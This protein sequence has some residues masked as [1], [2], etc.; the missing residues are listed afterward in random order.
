MDKKKIIDI[1][2]SANSAKLL[3]VDQKNWVKCLNSIS[4]QQFV[5]LSYK[6]SF[7]EYQKEYFSDVYEEYYDISMVLYR[8]GIPVGIWPL[9]IYKID[10]MYHWGS[11]GAYI[12]EPI[13]INLPKSEAQ[14]TVIQKILESFVKI[15]DQSEIPF[16]TKIKSQI[17]IMENGSSQWQRKWM[18]TGARCINTSWWAY[19]DLS[20]SQEEIQSRIR[21][22]NKYSIAKGETDYDIEIYDSDDII[23]SEVFSEFHKMH[24]KISGRETRSQ[25]TWD[26]QERS[27]R[28]NNDIM[29]YDFVIFIRDKKTRELAGSSLFAT[30]PQS[31]L[32]CV[33]AYD[34]ERFSKPV[35]HIVQAVA[36]EYMRKR[37]VR[38]YEIGE[39]VY[40]NDNNSN[41][42][43]VNIGKYKEGFATHMFPKIVMQLD[44]EEVK[45]NI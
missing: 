31:G 38:W 2:L 39:R 33:A 27:I 28:E 41:P 44:L 17:T 4:N 13:F 12:L 34:R 5:P 25:R 21:R 6:P 1:L 40:P 19:A 43:L 35:G 11:L 37:G 32:Y 23:L 26:I 24:R 36:M 3:K 15:T 30:T 9:C 29:G 22:T 42:K 18:E 16:A 7:I 45:N 14:R 20:L 10:H 8:G